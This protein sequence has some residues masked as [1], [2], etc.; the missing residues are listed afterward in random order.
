LVQVPFYS[1]VNLVAG[2]KIVPELMQ[3]EM[4]PERLA[5]EATRLLD[6]PGARNA[7]REELGLVAQSL[8]AVEDPLS[9]AAAKIIGIL[10]QN[11]L[12]RIS[13]ETE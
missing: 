4:T 6:Q 1:M 10:E 3:S 2:R 12:S 11:A 8:A 13:L 5:A 9:R 7:M